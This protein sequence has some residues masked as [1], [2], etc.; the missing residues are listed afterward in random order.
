VV[1]PEGWNAIVDYASGAGPRPRVEDARDTLDA[2]LDHLAVDACERREA[3]VNAVMR[4]SP[5]RL[6]PEAFGFRGRGASYWTSRGRPLDWFRSDDEVTLVAVDG[7]DQATAFD[8][9]DRPG[10]GTRRFAAML[11]PDDWLEYRVEVT[12]PGRLAVDVE[13]GPLDDHLPDTL[14][15]EVDGERITADPGAAG[16]DAGRVRGTTPR[17]VASGRHSVRITST[18]AGAVIRSIS[19]APQLNDA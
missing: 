5:I 17:P 3:V 14:V 12:A 4:R 16:P 2:Y 1:P 18:H 7:V 15:L 10:P 8:A 13:V 19:V 6:A 9:V 11:G